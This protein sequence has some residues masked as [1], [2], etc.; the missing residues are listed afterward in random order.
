[1]TKKDYHYYNR[2]TQND[3][4]KVQNEKEL[5]QKEKAE[6]KKIYEK[7]GRITINVT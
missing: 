4:E 7:S 2:E 5:I 6:L 1:M 3:S